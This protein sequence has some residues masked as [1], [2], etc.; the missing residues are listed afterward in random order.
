[1]S[2][3]SLQKSS[4]WTRRNYGNSI[5][6]TWMSWGVSQLASNPLWIWVHFHGSINPFR[7]P[8]ENQLHNPSRSD[9]NRWVALTGTGRALAIMLVL[10]TQSQGTRL[11]VHTA[12]LRYG[13]FGRISLYQDRCSTT[14]QCPTV[15]C[16]ST[17]HVGTKN[18]DPC[19]NLKTCNF[20]GWRRGITHHMRPCTLVVS[21]VSW[22]ILWYQTRMGRPQMSSLWVHQ[23][24]YEHQR[25]ST[26]F[27]AFQPRQ[28]ST[29][30]SLV[31]SWVIIKHQ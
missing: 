10:H 3:C 27:A 25:C 24:N 28:T 7:N 26:N 19:A 4:A 1:M 31:K 6:R 18:L 21:K 12:Q 22:N 20:K 5:L 23:T 8:Y 30:T 15:T 17:G 2:T 14:L 29:K 13:V 11:G 16:R 9:R